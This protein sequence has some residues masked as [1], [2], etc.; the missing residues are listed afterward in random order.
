MNAQLNT[1]TP[2]H[3]QM[4]EAAKQR[5]QANT[6]AAGTLR[7][8]E[9]AENVVNPEVISQGKTKTY[10]HQ[11]PG[12][13]FYMPDGLRVQFFGGQFTTDDLEII[14]ELDKVTNKPTSLV[15]SHIVTTKTVDP[16]LA[17]RAVEARGTVATGAGA[18]PLQSK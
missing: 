16:E 11:V 18:L 6:E 17:A 5:L 7:S 15:T 9:M 10:F 2:L 12:A 4:K 1:N 3:D 14:R 8:G 13:N